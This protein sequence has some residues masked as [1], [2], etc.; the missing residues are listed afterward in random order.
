MN[1][2]DSRVLYHKDARLCV[3]DV[4]VSLD[5]VQ[6]AELGRL[7]WTCASQSGA[8]CRGEQGTPWGGH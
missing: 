2:S 5:G 8:G 4:V 3:S 1:S 6:V 7:E